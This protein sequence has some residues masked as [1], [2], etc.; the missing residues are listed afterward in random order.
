M[1]SLGVEKVEP[2][3]PSMVDELPRIKELPRAKMKRDFCDYMNEKSIEKEECIE[4]EEKIEIS[5]EHPCTWTSMLGK[6]HTMEFEK[7]QGEFVGKELS[8]CH[9]DSLISPFLNPSFLSHKVYYVKLRLF[10]ASYIS[11]LSIIGDACSISFAGGL[12]LVV[13]YASTCLSSHAFLEE[14]LLNSGSMFDPSCHDF[15]F[16]NNASID[17]IVVGLTLECALLDILHDKCVEK[18]FQN[19]EWSR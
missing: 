10:L 14:L 6:N 4:T 16:M 17:S 2:L 18:F 15:G 8:L 9:E 19:V 5:L 12:F 13:P 3:T 1:P 7:E 11:H